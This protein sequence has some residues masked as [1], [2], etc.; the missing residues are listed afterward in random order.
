MRA[1]ATDEQWERCVAGLK[2][3]CEM[4]APYGIEF[5]LET[6]QVIHQPAILRLLGRD[7][8]RQLR[9][10]LLLLFEAVLVPPGKIHTSAG[11][12]DVL[13]Y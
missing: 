3:V 12:V 10:K 9:E 1:E 8:G 2:L 7:R 13:L 6:H 5:P 4:G 11:V